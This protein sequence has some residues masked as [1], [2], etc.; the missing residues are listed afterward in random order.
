MDSVA[1]LQLTIETMLQDPNTTE[2]TRNYIEEILKTISDQSKPKPKWFAYLDLYY[3][4]TDHSNIDGVSKSGKLYLKD[5][6]SDMDGVKY[7]KTYSRGGS[8]TVGKNIDATSA[9]SFNG[10]F[11]VNTQNKGIENESDVVSGSVSYSKVIGKNFLIP[12]A[13]YSRPNQ[14][15]SDD[16]KSIGMGFNNTYNINQNNSINYSASFSNTKFN[17][18]LNNRVTDPDK[19]NSD[20]YSGSIGYNFSFFDVNL[21]SSKFSYTEKKAKEL[22]GYEGT[23]FNIGY[24]RVLPFGN[25]KLDKTFQTNYF[26][27]KDTFIHSTINRKDDIETS[28]IQLSGR[29]TQLLPFMKKFDPG[30]KI[31][32]NFNFTEIDSSSTLLQNVHLEKV[33]ALILPRGFLFMNKIKTL[34]AKIIFL[35]SSISLGFTNDVIIGVIAVGVGEIINQDSE[36]LT[37]GSKI[38]FGDTIIT[39]AQSNAQILLLDETAITVG[40][41]SELTIDEFVYDPQ[42]KVGK[43]VS[44][45]KIGTVRIITGEISKKNPD[46]LEVNVP[47]GSIGARGTEF[48]VVTT[49][50]QKSTILLLGPGKNNTLGMVPGVLNVSDGSNTVN[51]ATPGFQSVVFK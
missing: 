13:Y 15:Y 14:N 12:Y 40:E 19:K 4:Q 38:Y 45:I 7:D 47:T 30:G 42:S 16:Y 5:A 17:N 35:L 51:I 18:K 36:K 2:E 41:K 28:V 10:G 6:I 33:L 32:Y 31:F 8:I 48:V 9:I 27:E 26:D 46:N 3:K 22:F 39:K 34:I 24:T 49:S 43:I 50:D 20:I 25:L 37:T 29:I 23:G 21:I 1:K 44:N 11:S